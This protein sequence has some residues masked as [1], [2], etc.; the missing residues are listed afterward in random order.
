MSCWT[1]TGREDGKV[2]G[3]HSQVYISKLVLLSCKRQWHSQGIHFL[4]GLPS[5]D[6]RL[7]YESHQEGSTGQQNT[8]TNHEIQRI[9]IKCSASDILKPIMF[10]ICSLL[11]CNIYSQYLSTELETDSNKNPAAEHP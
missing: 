6:L 11:A 3:S 1:R 8:T 5:C 10:C 9:S 4:S 2:D 7:L